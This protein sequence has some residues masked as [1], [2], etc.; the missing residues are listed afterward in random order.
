[1]RTL[2][3]LLGMFCESELFRETFGEVVGDV[4]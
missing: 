1:M 4:L 2:G 3:K